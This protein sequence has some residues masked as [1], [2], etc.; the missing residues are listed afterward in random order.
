MGALLEQND[1][2]AVAPRYMRLEGLSALSDDRLLGLS[3][4]AA[5][6]P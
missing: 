3:A 4:V 1:E 2:W 6:S 5:W